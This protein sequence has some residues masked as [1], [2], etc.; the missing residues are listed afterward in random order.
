[1]KRKKYRSDV[2]DKEWEILKRHLPEPSFQGNRKYELREIVNG[3]YYLLRTGCGWE[4][5]PHDL[6]DAKSC[7]WYFE[8][9]T[10]NKVWEK[11]QDAVREELRKKMG[12]EREP[13]VGIIDSQSIKTADSGEEVGYDRN[14]KIRG[15]K[16][17]I[18]VDTNGFMLAC[19][20][21]GAD[22]GDREGGKKVVDEYKK[23]VRKDGVNID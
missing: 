11:A 4:Y 19:K 1:M 15:R 3:I 18:M 16:R 5:I 21:T 10:K 22:I 23:K 6:P 2:S 17:H 13:S 7:R 9:W 8:K 12:K 14:K 20:V